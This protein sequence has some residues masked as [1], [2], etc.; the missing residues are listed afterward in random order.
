MKVKK[1]SAEV[2]PFI[3]VKKILQ[4]DKGW[5]ESKR[6]GQRVFQFIFN[7]FFN[8]DF[9]YFSINHKINNSWVILVTGYWLL[10]Q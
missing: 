8:F 9:N 6:G 2:S 1:K 3:R 7:F 10:P 5:R 4:P